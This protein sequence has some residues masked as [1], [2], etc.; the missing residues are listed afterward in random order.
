[1]NHELW[2]WANADSPVSRQELP[3]IVCKLRS[4]PGDHTITAVVCS[5]QADIP[6]EL[7]AADRVLRIA[8][9]GSPAW[10]GAQLA[11]LAKA[12]APWAIVLPNTRFDAQV[13]AT[14]A[15]L[16]QT[17]LSADCTDLRIEDDLLV[18]HRPAF[19]G[20]VEADILCPDARPQ[21][22]TIHP[23]VFTG[24]SPAASPAVEVLPPY[25]AADPVRVL[26]R[27][28]G[29]EQTTLR[30]AKL[31]VAGGLGVGSKEGFALL[32]RLARHL[33]GELA[34]SR[35]AVDAGF[36]PWER[37]IGQ[38]GCQVSPDIYL[39]FGI[40]GAIRHIA[41]MRNAKRV[42]AVNTDPRAPI[43]SYADLAIVAD[44]RE[45]AEYL[46]AH[47]PAVPQKN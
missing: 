32:E 25:D 37:Q 39:A 33:G 12:R 27:F 23:G 30:A 16:L 24:V 20:G 4:L 1:M 46:L 19:G 14:A 29:S 13:A 43:F 44:W 40:S 2:L 36:A 5:V 41:G 17:G 15:A 22:A 8:A 42:V 38:T 18:M 31:I 35:A 45:T 34:A 7:A 47:L 3:G 26:E 6:A 21:M 10:C 9:V 11:A 28:P